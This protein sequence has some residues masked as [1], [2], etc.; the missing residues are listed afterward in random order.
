[1]PTGNMGD[2]KDKKTKRIQRNKWHKQ[3]TASRFN[4]LLRLL[5]IYAFPCLVIRSYLF[6]IRNKSKL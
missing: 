2:F 6:P 3:I 1:M 4:Q 5:V